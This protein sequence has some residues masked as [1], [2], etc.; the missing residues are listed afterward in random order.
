MFSIFDGTS[1]PKTDTEKKIATIVESMCESSAVDVR[2]DPNNKNVF[3]T[4]EEKHYD[5]VLTD[6]SVL[7]SNTTYLSREIFTTEFVAY[8]KA[9]AYTRASKDRQ[10]KLAQILKR[11]QE[12]LTKIEE[13]LNEKL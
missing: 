1:K 2:I 12:L 7:I 4:H 13:N 10:E 6:K 11:E 9:L 5:V 8:L 3:L